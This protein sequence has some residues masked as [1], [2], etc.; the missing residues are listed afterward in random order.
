MPETR[1]LGKVLQELRQR[2]G[3]TQ[4][5][6]ADL[7]GLS[8]AGLRDVEQGRVATP[9]ARTIRLLGGALGLSATEVADLVALARP[10]P[11]AA[12]GV[13]LGVLGPLALRVD[14]VEADPGSETQRV[15]LGLL[16]LAANATV[17][18][19]ELLEVVW[20]G[21]PPANVGTV[22]PTRISRL[23]R[24]LAPAAPGA[25]PPELVATTGGYR[26]SCQPEQLDLL[27]FHQL[28][29]RARQ[30]Q[31]GGEPA[32]AA[33]RYAEAMT[34]W[35]GEPLAGLAPLADHPAVTAL[36]RLWQ[37][38]V[39]EYATVAIDLGRN[40]RVVPL[41]QQVVTG[42]S[43]HELAHA[44]LMLAL[45]GSGQQ[46]TALTL[47]DDLR[48]RLADELGASPGPELTQAHRRVLRQQVPRPEVAPVRAHR[49]LPPDIADFCGR[50]SELRW[51]ADR[52]PPID[53]PAPRPTAPP[54]Y[55]LEGMG[56]VG[57]TRLAV[58]VAHQL[59]AAGR[60]AEQQ[61]YV[62][63]HGHADE[64]PADPAAVLASF[65]Q[66]LAVPGDQIPADLP[67]RSA[68]FR[69]RLH[70]RPSL[71]LLDNAASEEQVRPLLPASPENLVLITSRRSLAIDGAHTL[72]LDVFS[73][74]EATEL[75]IQVVGADRVGSDPTAARQVVER[76]GR[77]PLAVALVARRLQARPAWRL[78][79]LAGRIAEARH[80]LAELAAGTRALRSV[81]DLSYQALDPPT[82]RTF[83]L[84]GLHPGDDVT[85]YSAAALTG[86]TVSAAQGC[87]DRLVDEHLVIALPG[88]RYRLHDL[89]RAYAHDLAQQDEPTAQEAAV[90]QLLTWYLSVA[91]TAHRQISP[92]NEL[93][94][95]SVPGGAQAPGIVS[96][97][98]AVAWLAAEQANL[99]AIVTGAAGD[100][101][102]EYAWQLAA[103]L[104]HLFLRVGDWQEWI[105]VAEAGL[106]AARHCGDRHGET[107][108]RNDLG[109]AYGNSGDLD[110]A[111]ALLA[112][113]VQVSATLPDQTQQARSRNNLGIALTLRGQTTEAIAELQRALA[114]AEKPTLRGRTLNNLGR[115]YTVQGDYP[116][117]IEC[118]RAALSLLTDSSDVW[119]YAL[120]LGVLGEALTFDG[121]FAEAVTVL[122]RACELHRQQRAPGEEVVLLRLLSDALTELGEDEQAAACRLRAESLRPPPDGPPRPSE[123]GRATAH[124]VDLP[125]P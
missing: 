51:L 20:G 82:Q 90:T 42:D 112:E 47:F 100:N 54:I 75:L 14:G 124:P 5:E 62:D 33:D 85:P 64:P 60:Y 8:V 50:Q 25:V 104:R 19:E 73:E 88:D 41:L 11:R 105:R 67:S 99:I 53:Q 80:R 7:A 17:S 10:N 108:M 22:L 114:L 71:L 78:A 77:L 118:A 27:H 76:C 115:S 26:L 63:L 120:A 92:G 95:P 34:L 93:P 107:L 28:V 9:R 70:G 116:A 57:K 102:R 30:H 86:T 38:V 66:L 2:V 55:A 40:D 79:D 29:G 94:A 56:G 39:V 36:L 101:N 91:A 103:T 119:G 52:L 61:L 12:G 111:V 35:R 81:F 98:D 46:A 49:Q 68:L 125:T 21:R 44:K 65:L 24:R 87:L 31:A 122:R 16:S 123:L 45:A 23:R 106:A 18:R 58:R 121:Q 43:L 3:L 117:A 109:I 72:P 13:W 15:L 1:E 113:A 89:L 59:L 97:D 48:R 96:D 110:R 69:D 4:Q 83:R 84:L 74:Q 32:L 37:T 6:A